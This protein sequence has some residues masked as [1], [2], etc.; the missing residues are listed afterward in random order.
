MLEGNQVST[1][2]PSVRMRDADAYFQAQ[3]FHAGSEYD[4]QVLFQIPLMLLMLSSP[5]EVGKQC[6]LLLVLLF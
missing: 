5:G 3:D 2:E 6:P 1:E 4:V